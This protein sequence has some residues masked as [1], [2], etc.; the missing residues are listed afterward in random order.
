MKLSNKFLI[1]LLAGS[2]FVGC[3]QYTDKRG[4]DVTWQPDA[5]AQLEK[6][7]STRKDVLALLGP[8]SQVISLG[9]ETVLY[10]LYEKAEGQGYI[11]I[12]YNRFDRTTD[13]DRA[14]FF[15]NSDDVLTEYAT[16]IN[17]DEA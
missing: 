9:D 3:A 16:W 11:L 14:V 1:S 7:K 17:P 6:G 15:F 10:Y 12:L 2:L 5:V 13:Y 4:V 8:P